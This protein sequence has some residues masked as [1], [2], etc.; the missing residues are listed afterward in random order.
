MI[1]FLYNLLG[2]LKISATLAWGVTHFK[3][4]AKAR[5]FSIQKVGSALGGVLSIPIFFIFNSKAFANWIGREGDEPARVL[6]YAQ[7]VRIAIIPQIVTF[8]YIAFFVK[9]RANKTT[10]F[11]SSNCLKT[12][13][14]LK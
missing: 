1:G 8:I 10:R 7:Y 14:Y 6:D 2:V 12:C 4:E 5:G 9:E 13:S 11:I 3:P